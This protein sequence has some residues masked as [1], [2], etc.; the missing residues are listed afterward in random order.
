MPALQELLSKVKKPKTPPLLLSQRPAQE[1]PIPR[2]GKEIDRSEDEPRPWIIETKEEE[3]Q[4][5]SKRTHTEEISSTAPSPAL[6]TPLEGF[7]TPQSQES[8]TKADENTQ[9]TLNTTYNKHLTY[10][11]T[12]TE[13]LLNTEYNNGLTNTDNSHIPSE[14]HPTKT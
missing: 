14:K 3:I 6:H 4:A 2:R 7:D 8:V 12:N 11:I 13:Q 9:Q 5:D 1:I 10:R